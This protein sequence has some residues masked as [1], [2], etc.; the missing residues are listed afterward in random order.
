MIQCVDQLLKKGES[1]ELIAHFV[2]DAQKWTELRSI[3]RDQ[4]HI[5]R[6]FAVE[7]CRRY[8]GD[9]GLNGV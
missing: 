2:K 4:V 3:L 7:Y 5:A 8:N 1:S 9:K 6:G